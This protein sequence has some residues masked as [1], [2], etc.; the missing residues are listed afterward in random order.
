MPAG[1]ALARVETWYIYGFAG[2]DIATIVNSPNYSD[3]P[4]ATTA[5]TNRLEVA[6]TGSTRSFGSR[7]TTYI[8]APVS[9]NYTF[10]VAGVHRAHLFVSTDTSDINK[11]LIAYTSYVEQY[12]FDKYASQQSEPMYLVA[13]ESYYL[14]GLYMNSAKGDHFEAA[15]AIP[16]TPLDP[17]IIAGKYFSLHPPPQ[18]QE[19][20][21]STVF[22]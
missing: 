19:T 22:T 14:E 7:V 20:I 12:E 15:W 9:G 21:N 6:D 16:G 8:T 2:E 17:V 5:L 1:L 18:P 13:G 11:R 10:W 3:F 4:D